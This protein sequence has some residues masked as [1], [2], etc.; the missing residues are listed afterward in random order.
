MLTLANHFAQTI[1]NKYK[2]KSLDSGK[3]MRGEQLPICK[4]RVEPLQSGWHPSL[5]NIMD[6][7]LSRH[8]VKGSGVCGIKLSAG[9]SVGR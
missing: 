9:G 6:V 7:F 2:K 4:E 5:F 8:K 1:Y 3:S